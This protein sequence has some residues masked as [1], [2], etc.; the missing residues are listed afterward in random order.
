MRQEILKR[1]SIIQIEEFNLKIGD[2]V[3]IT[4]GKNSS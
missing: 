2:M 3:I 1:K 4:I